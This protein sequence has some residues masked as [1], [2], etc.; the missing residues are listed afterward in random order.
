[1][2]NN[3]PTK[4][5][6]CTTREAAKILGISLRTAQ[7]WTESGLL[8]AWKTSG[9]HRRISRKS[10]ELL[11]AKP[12]IRELAAESSQARRVS[13]VDTG[14]PAHE[15]LNI[16]VVEDDPTLCLLYEYKLR[17]W[18]MLP[19]VCTVSDGYEALIRMGHIK[20]DIL[21]A[22]LH[23]PGMDGFKMLN[24]IRKAPELSGIQIIVVS[25][26][27]QEEI[28]NRGGVPKDIPVL[29]KPIPFDQLQAFA[30]AVD[31]K[32]QNPKT[33]KLP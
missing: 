22:D 19:N 13:D 14:T 17:G 24:I 8:E 6:F 1:M 23:M 26:L 16:M 10:I 18:P 28:A 32:R 5:I 11:L 15:A 30:N 21:I 4:K 25:G 20:P 3:N 2:N 12:V 33:K 7:L 27:N 29:P 9:G 31:A